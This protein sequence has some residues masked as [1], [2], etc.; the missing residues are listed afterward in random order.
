MQR[1]MLENQT[2][3][4]KE[5]AYAVAF[6]AANSLGEKMTVTFSPDRKPKA[7]SPLK[8]AAWM[9]TRNETISCRFLRQW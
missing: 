4:T 6:N 9:C 8:N 7:A 5:G 1:Y 2:T 3:F